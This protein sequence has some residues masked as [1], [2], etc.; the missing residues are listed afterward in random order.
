MTTVTHL[1]ALGASICVT[2]VNFCSP[3][4]MEAKV[5]DSY[6]DDDDDDDDE[7]DEDEDED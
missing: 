4:P 2:V 6:D 1:E 7:E 5:A 3:P